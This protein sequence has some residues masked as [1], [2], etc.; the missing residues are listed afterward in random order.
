[1]SS[2]GVSDKLYN[3]FQESTIL[4]ICTTTIL[5]VLALWALLVG[6]LWLWVGSLDTFPQLALSM[7]LAVTTIASLTVAAISLLTS[8]R[9]QRR[10]ETLK[11]YAEWS[12]KTRENFIYLSSRID[13]NTGLSDSQVRVILEP[14]RAS[15]ED[16]LLICCET[17]GQAE[18]VGRSIR[19]ILN[20]LERLSLGVHE[21]VYDKSTLNYMAGTSMTRRYERFKRYIVAVQRGVHSADDNSNAYKNLEWL[22]DDLREISK[23]EESKKDPRRAKLAKRGR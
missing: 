12:D 16:L 13:L 3:W 2:K 23:K 19:S 7:F 20:A 1:M 5:V 21:G 6:L 8:S 15:K 14:D 4:K 9:R 22:V 17:P 11:A 18:M 10:L